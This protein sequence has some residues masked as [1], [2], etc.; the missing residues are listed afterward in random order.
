MGRVREADASAVVI[1][2]P[3]LTGPQRNDG[4]EWETRLSTCAGHFRPGSTEGNGEAASGASLDFDLGHL[5]RAERDVGE[6]LCAGRAGEPDGFLV[7]LGRLFTGEIHVLILEN[8][9]QAILEHA[10][11]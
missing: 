6:E 3:H 9:V 2:E 8:L 1:T 10:L 7:L 5:E 4:A 11:E